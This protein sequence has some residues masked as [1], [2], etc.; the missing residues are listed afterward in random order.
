MAREEG[1]VGSEATSKFEVSAPL[2]R[3]E[4]AERPKSVKWHRLDYYDIAPLTD[5][6]NNKTGVL[7]RGGLVSAAF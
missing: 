2:L 1:S 7:S 6:E 3:A 5:G 4:D